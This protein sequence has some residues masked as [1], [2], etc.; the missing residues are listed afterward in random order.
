MQKQATRNAVAF[1]HRGQ[2]LMNPM[3]GMIYYVL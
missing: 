3:A 1:S 2:R